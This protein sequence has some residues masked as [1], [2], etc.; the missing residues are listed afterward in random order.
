MQDYVTKEGFNF[1]FN[2][3]ACATCDG[4]CCIGESGYVWVS[5]EQISDIAN[6]LD[7][8][9]DDFIDKHLRKVRFKYSLKEIKV[10]EKNYICEF[11]D[12]S[13]KRCQ[14]YEVRPTQCRTFPFWEYFINNTKEVEEECPGILRL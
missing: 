1:A 4:N 9:K 13:S 7:L 14:I 11:F 8:N 5:K 10:D 2:E 6:F 12:L 3:S